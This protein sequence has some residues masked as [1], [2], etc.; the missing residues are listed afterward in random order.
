[1]QF[2]SAPCRAT[3]PPDA[4]MCLL[5]HDPFSATALARERMERQ[6]QEMTEACVAFGSLPI[7][8]DVEG[9]TPAP[10][11]SCSRPGPPICSPG[12]LRATCSSCARA[13]PTFTCAHGAVPLSSR[14]RV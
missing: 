13:D 6:H 7:W 3:C 5:A 2:A 8:F 1:M 4:D 11:P 12:Y 9:W 14:R 10:G